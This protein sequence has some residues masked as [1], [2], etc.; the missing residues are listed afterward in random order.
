MHEMERLI[1]AAREV[2]A[3]PAAPAVED[4]LRL[5]AGWGA[6]PLPLQP[7]LHALADEFV[8]R[9][10][11]IGAWTLADAAVL[12]ERATP[13]E[14][15]VFAPYPDEV[16]DPDEYGPENTWWTKIA[17]EMQIMHRLIV[18]VERAAN[19]PETV[20]GFRVYGAGQWL[21]ESLWAA[22]GVLPRDPGAPN[23]EH[24]RAALRLARGDELAEPLA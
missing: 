6:D 20:G 3:V 18:L 14:R 11:A 12:A 8:D 4:V 19:D 16:F 21:R 23:G 15:E 24:F 2:H 7:V 22:T 9:S 10:L 1:A 5:L 13:E 17:H